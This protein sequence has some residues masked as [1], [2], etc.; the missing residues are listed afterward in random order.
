MARKRVRLDDQI[1]QRRAEVLAEALPWI[2]ESA[3]KTFV[4]KYG[5]S[6][7]EDPE[8]CRQVVADI[9]LMKLVGIRVVLVHGG[10]KAISRLMSELDLKVAFKDGLR[11]TDD[12]AMRAVQM[13]LVGEVNQ[14]LVSQ[15]N[16]YGDYGVSITGADGRT[17]EAVPISPEL[18]RVGAV[19]HV[20]TRLI[21]SVL[22]DGYIPVIAGVGWAPSGAYNIN[23]DLAASEIA[24]ALKADKL[25]YLSDVD[26]LYRDFSDK[27]SLLSSLTLDDARE[28]IASGTLESGMIPKVRSSADALEAGVDRVHFLNGTYPHS[29]LLEIFTDA[30]IGTM[31]KQND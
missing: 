17:L 27:D 10:G 30:G 21:E 7:M 6:A 28:L 26:G 31:F 8:L 15:V 14:M 12:A 22:D 11:V 1:N 5:G 13:A 29:I 4:V 3:G 20:N 19:C 9:V 25:I 18:G 24:I 2:N 23:A 16:A